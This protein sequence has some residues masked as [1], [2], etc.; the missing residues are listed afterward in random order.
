MG[1]EVL[2]L[3]ASGIGTGISAI[4]AINSANA[5]AKNAAYQAQV[6]RNNQITAARNAQ[7]AS[8]AGAATT[9]AA[10]LKQRS[11][12]ADITAAAGASGVDIN[13]GSPLAVRRSEAELGQLN[14][15][16]TAQNTALNIYGYR[17]QE[18]N[19]GA[20]AGIEQNIAAQAPVAGAIS[21][22]GTLLSGAGSLASKWLSWQ[23]PNPA[24]P[25]AEGT[26]GLY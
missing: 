15:Q 24:G 14:T 17:V 21:A 7:Y 19:F 16:N 1:L 10:Q 6:A 26:G 18:S 9:T 11:E 5:T 12:L 2:A 4:G 23:N 25:A 13:S 8:Q 3:A 20:Q 22:S